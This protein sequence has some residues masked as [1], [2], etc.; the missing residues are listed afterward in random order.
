MKEDFVFHL[1]DKQLDAFIELMNK[2]PENQRKVVP[3]GFETNLH[4]HLG[5]VLTV[6]EYHVFGSKDQPLN[7]P[8]LYQEMFTYSTKPANWTKEP[9]LWERLIAQLEELRNLIH[10]SLKAKLDIPVRNNIL[11]A[12]NYRELLFA[13][14]QHLAT[15]IGVVTAM[16][17]ILR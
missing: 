17:Q 1:F 2:C 6:T 12:N 13:T 11:K 7:L 9:P 16:L 4:W 10:Q 5:H 14:S 8:K 15:H 3:N